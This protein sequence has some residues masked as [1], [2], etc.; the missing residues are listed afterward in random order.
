[1]KKRRFISPIIVF[2]LAQF[3]WF[4]LLAL[5]IYWYVSNYMIFIEVGERISPQF[6]VSTKNIAA[7][8]GGILLLMSIAVALALIYG[9]LNQQMKLNKMYDTFIAN[10][11]HEL[12]SPLASIQLYLETLGSR[13]VPTERR[14]EF[15]E[16]MLKDSQRLN[17]LINSILEISGLE[18][19]KKVYHPTFYAADELFQQ[20]VN[21]AAEQF[22]LPKGSVRFIGKTGSICKTD[23]RSMKIVLNNLFDNAIKYSGGPV[24]LTVKVTT[25][26]GRLI[27]RTGDQGIGILEKDQREIF[28]KFRRISSAYSPSVKGTGLGLYWVKEIIRQHHGKI[29]VYSAGLNRGTTFTIELPTYPGK[30]LI[31]Q[32]KKEVP[33]E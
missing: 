31:V 17:A 25:E 20:L 33:Y 18:E 10:V 5:W 16:L 28:K 19:R 4:S 8:V 13:E 1:M 14:T 24:N 9:R 3:A 7:L 29:S 2:I 11:T 6:V 30:S 23:R 26:S 21:E 22:N 27:V 32:D 12:K 15:I